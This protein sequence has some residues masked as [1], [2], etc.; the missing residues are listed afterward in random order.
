MPVLLLEETPRL[1]DRQLPI[2]VPLWGISRARIDS[3][4]VW[5]TVIAP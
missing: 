1:M 3:F 2:E 4:I 5:A